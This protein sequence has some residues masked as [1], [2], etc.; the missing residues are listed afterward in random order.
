MIVLYAI[1]YL[2]GVFFFAGLLHGFA[3]D[4]DADGPLIVLL[5]LAWP[6]TM[7]SI[8]VVFVVFLLVF[9]GEFLGKKLH[10]MLDG[11]EGL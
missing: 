2:A 3:S 1:G 6:L 11:L 5:I 8:F 4:E 10:D 9:V 7:V